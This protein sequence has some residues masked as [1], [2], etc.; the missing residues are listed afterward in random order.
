MRFLFQQ[1][2]EEEGC[3]NETGQH[4]EREFRTC[5]RAC[6]SVDEQQ[7]D[8]SE[9]ERGGKKSPVVRADNGAADVRHNKTH[10][11]HCSS[12]THGG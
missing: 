6:K 11:R 4:S 9:K 10:P 8:A 5:Q 1:D 3:T 7:E 12:Q 2:S